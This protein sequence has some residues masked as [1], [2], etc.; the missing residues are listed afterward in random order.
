MEAEF[1][2]VYVQKQKDM[3][4]DLIARVL[5]LDARATLLEKQIKQQN[6]DAERLKICEQDLATLRTRFET[7]VNS[8][9]TDFDK[10]AVDLRKQINNLTIDREQLQNKINEMKAALK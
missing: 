4:N 10:K 3:I 2:N 6:D 9:R 1:V 7:E 8:V 5:M